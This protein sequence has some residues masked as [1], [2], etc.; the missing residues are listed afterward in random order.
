MGTS[1]YFLQTAVQVKLKTKEEKEK[2]RAKAEGAGSGSGSA[3][4]SAAKKKDEVGGEV[5]S[6]GQIR[7]KLVVVPAWSEI[8]GER[9][10]A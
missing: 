9:G 10:L 3:G 6:F 1:P 2:E 7:G 8:L 4:E 5:V